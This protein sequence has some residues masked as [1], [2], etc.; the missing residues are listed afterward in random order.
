[1]K[2]YQNVFEKLVSKEFS[3]SEIDD[4]KTICIAT[5][6][7]N[8]IPEINYF[9]EDELRRSAYLVDK[10]MRFNC[11]SKEQKYQLKH[12]LDSIKQKLFFED[13]FLANVEP[14]AKKW[15]INSDIQHLFRE[16]LFLQK[17]HYKHSK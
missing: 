3:Y 13:N 4:L 10:L 7:E 14:L 9:S 8:F 5:W 15:N 1:M 16:L 17:R 11:V 12:I 6:Y 2:N